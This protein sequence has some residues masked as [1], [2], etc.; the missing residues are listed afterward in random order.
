MQTNAMISSSHAAA[1]MQTVSVTNYK[2]LDKWMTWN[3][4]QQQS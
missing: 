4:I 2:G 1:I 3:G